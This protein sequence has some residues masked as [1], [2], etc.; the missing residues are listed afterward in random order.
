[1]TRHKSKKKAFEDSKNDAKSDTTA[2]LA[3]TKYPEQQKIFLQ[4]AAEGW[5][6]PSW[7]CP[8]NHSNVNLLLLSGLR[9]VVSPSVTSRAVLDIILSAHPKVCIALRSALLRYPLNVF[10]FVP[11]QIR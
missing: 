4:F 6:T 8:F 1:M 10:L 9:T 5:A 3:N 7:H 2:V 11:D